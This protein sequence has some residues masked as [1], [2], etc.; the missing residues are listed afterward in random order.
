MWS[1]FNINVAKSEH[2]EI[3][4][5]RVYANIH[6][7][8]YVYVKIYVNVATCLHF[9][10]DLTS[11]ISLYVQFFREPQFLLAKG[12]HVIEEIKNIAQSSS[13]LVWF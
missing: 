13:D 8:S 4:Y 7:F 1:L 2:K 9:P 5:V 6:P 11:I 10:W 12:T 3:F